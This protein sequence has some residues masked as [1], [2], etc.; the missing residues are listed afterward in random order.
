MQKQFINVDQLRQMLMELKTSTFATIET[1]TEARMNK[2]GNP[3]LGTKKISAA[4]VNIN[5]SYANAVN[6]QRDKENNEEEFVPH[7]RKWGQRIPKTPLIEHKGEFYLEARFM[8]APSNTTY[9]FNGKIIDKRELTPFMPEN[10]SNAEHQGVE[11]EIIIRDFKLSN[12]S[13]IILNKTHYK[14]V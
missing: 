5:F 3:F 11:K 9:V 10:N 1:V 13:E 12:I 8:N 2:K 4:N 14:I 6:K 7:A